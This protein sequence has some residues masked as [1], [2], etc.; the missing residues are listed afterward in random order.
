MEEI[1]NIICIIIIFCI[2]K[3]LC[4]QELPAV[5]ISAGLL[6]P[7]CSAIYLYI[8]FEQSSI[9]KGLLLVIFKVLFCIYGG[10]HCRATSR[11]GVSSYKRLLLR[12]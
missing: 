8:L 9:Y 2:N 10:K 11:Y 6:L 3:M 12:R 7:L 1:K 4:T 5:A